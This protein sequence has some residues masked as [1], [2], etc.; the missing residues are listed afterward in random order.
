[1]LISLKVPSGDTVRVV[2]S[3]DKIVLPD[4]IIIQC[5][6]LI[7]YMNYA[8]HEKLSELFASTGVPLLN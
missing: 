5:A 1:M 3:H 8:F 7:H 2:P 6:N 4:P